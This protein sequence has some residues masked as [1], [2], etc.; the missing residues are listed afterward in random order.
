L[1]I[2]KTLIIA[3]AGVNHNGNLQKAIDLIHAAA[4]A[5]ADIVKFQTFSAEKLTSKTA[6][7]AQYQKL[8]TDPNKSQYEMLKELELS[9]D[10]FRQLNDECKSEGIE[11]LSTG[12]DIS[13]IQFL[14]EFKMKRY[15][16]P[17]GELTNLPY[18]RYIGSLN[19]PIILST[20]MSTL[21]EIG[22]ALHILKEAGTPKDNITILHCNTEYPTP[23]EDV[24]LNAM[25][26][27]KKKLGVSIG[28]SDHTL[29]L[30]IP[31]AAVALGAS[32]VEKHLTLDR[33]LPGPDH[34]ASIEPGELKEM[35][36]LI[37]NVENALGNGIKE[38]SR[39]ELKNIVVA[40]KSIVAAKSIKRGDLFTEEN[41]T[42][43]RPGTGISPMRW[44]HIIGTIA[45]REY[46]LDDLIK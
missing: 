40:R 29:G 35:V 31:I 19:K 11:F 7:K 33:Y 4:N 21:D 34:R 22:A 39:S 41:L 17:S 8:I 6:E 18:L 25:L 24:N 20:G 38:P 1:S 37:R 45:D 23:V 46:K 15:K 30:E 16:I 36:R 2:N 5:G 27:I 10:T 12:F 44:D 42:A 9:G 13:D 14:S 28:Y 26:S 43:K 32:V 3:E